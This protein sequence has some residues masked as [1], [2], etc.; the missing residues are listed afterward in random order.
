M[1][2]VFNAQV[3]QELSKRIGSLAPGAERKWGT[4]TVERMLAHVAD[5]LRSAV[6]ELEVKP[7]NTPLRY[8]PLRYLVLYWLPFPKGAPTAPELIARQPEPIESEIRAVQELLER[9]AQREGQGQWPEHAA[10]G[11]MSEKDWGVLQYRHLDHHLKQFN[12]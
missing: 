4:M 3:R 9:F 8:A 7:K 12:A 1:T 2:T 11:K 6:G 5:G 10:F